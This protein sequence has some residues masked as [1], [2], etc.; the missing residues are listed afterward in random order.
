MGLKMQG[1]IDD[2][3]RLNGPTSYIFTIFEPGI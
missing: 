3:V 2:E 1:Y